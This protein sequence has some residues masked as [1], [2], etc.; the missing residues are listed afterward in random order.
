MA[1]RRGAGGGGGLGGGWWGVQVAHAGC[2]LGCIR[3]SREHLPLCISG[4][5]LSLPGCACCMLSPHPATCLNFCRPPRLPCDPCLS[6]TWCVS[7]GGPSWRRR[8]SLP[9]SLWRWLSAPA[10]PRPRL[11]PPAHAPGRAASVGSPPGRRWCEG[12]SCA[13]DWH[14]SSFVNV[15]CISIACSHLQTAVQRATAFMQFT[16]GWCCIASEW[17]QHGA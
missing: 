13:T 16:D 17:R 9:P 7:C 15:Y 6:Q 11:P 4:L 8:R 1:L 10:A 14:C 5:V 3:V 12:H 2:H